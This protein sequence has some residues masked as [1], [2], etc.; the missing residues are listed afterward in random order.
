MGNATARLLLDANVLLTGLFAPQSKSREVIVRIFRGE[1]AAYAIQN[2]I[3][4]CEGAIVRAA[5]NTGIDLLQPFKDSIN[6]IRLVIL[7]RVSREEG[8]TYTEIKG[9]GDRAIAAAA[10]RLLPV[11]ICTNDLS[12]FK[13]ADRYGLC[14][15]T[16]QQLAHDGSV[17]LHSI[18]PG[19]VVTPSRG[20]IYAEVSQ[21]NWAGV[22]FPQTAVDK[23]YVF[24]AENIGSC[25]FEARS[26][27]L[28]VAI[29]AGPT[30]KI[31]NVVNNAA[32]VPVSVVF[33]YD[34]TSEATVYAHSQNK[35]STVG[36]WSP[37]PLIAAPRTWIGSDRRGSNQ[38]CGCIR[39]V[40][41]MPYMVSE[42]AARNM[43]RGNTVNNPWER[44]SLEDIIKFCVLGGH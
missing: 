25:Y 28:L 17:G 36:A 9:T 22:T 18:V 15:S 7:P 21:L 37:K 32:S 33:T 43:I 11:V 19:L 24:D 35:A 26:N 3:E 34:C 13:C 40:S 41:G 16:P 14:V 10:V 44:L 29:D 30:V 20:T 42:R 4:E 12:D 38:L 8:Q 31:P 6:V 2:T 23:F 39:I 5:A 1:I 27:S